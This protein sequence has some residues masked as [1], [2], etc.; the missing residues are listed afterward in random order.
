MD[1]RHWQISWSKVDMGQDRHT[2]KRPHNIIDSIFQQESAVHRNQSILAALHRIGRDSIYQ[3]IVNKI[4][5]E[6]E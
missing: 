4:K 2:S 1:G 3:I 5:K 6:M